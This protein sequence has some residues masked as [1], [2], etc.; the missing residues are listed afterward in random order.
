MGY[1]RVNWRRVH[2]V[3]AANLLSVMRNDF[4]EN[5]KKLGV[6]VKR[7]VRIIQAIEYRIGDKWQFSNFLEHLPQSPMHS[8]I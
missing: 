8:H 2:T 5:R 1:R 6:H 7:F 3:A 4:V